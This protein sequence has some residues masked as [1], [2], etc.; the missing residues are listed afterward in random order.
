M[1]ISKK[2]LNSNLRQPLGRTAG[3]A[4]FDHKNR[5]KGVAR[6]ASEI[7]PFPSLSKEA[8]LPPLKNMLHGSSVGI[9]SFA[10][11][12]RPSLQV[13]L[14]VGK[15][16]GVKSDAN[17]GVGHQGLQ[18][19]AESSVGA[20]VK[21]LKSIHGWAD[22]NLIEDI[23]ASVDNDIDTA[24]SLLKSMVSSD[25]ETEE[26]A[27]LSAQKASIMTKCDGKN[28]GAGEK[29]LAEDK[30]VNGVNEL[31]APKQLCKVPIEPEW[32]EDDV[33]LSH[34]KDALRM[35]RVA[36]Q[37]SRAASNA[38]LRGDHFSAHQLSLK[39]REEWMAAER[40]NHKAAEEILRINNNINDMWKLDLHGLHPTEAVT[41]VNERLHKIESQIFLNSSAS[42]DELTA[43]VACTRFP[44]L[45][46]LSSIATDS[47]AAKKKVPSFQRRSVLNIITGIGK[48]SR[49]QAI[50][51][52]AVK[53]FLVEN[54][55]RFEETR[56]GSIAVQ[57]K[58]GH[59]RSMSQ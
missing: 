24:C 41:A 56:P 51:P 50:L 22:D 49:G 14:N 28:K 36:S 43:T 25:P 38:F 21:W 26:A 29:I 16:I 34:R 55:Y 13:S 18:L 52:A 15:Y 45:E 35:M 54:K 12:A 5:E 44:S 27:T 33:Y 46:S 39:A 30:L 6:T 53:N 59:I 23:L 9:K 32:E 10:S 4:A 17:S 42:S 48:N 57:P 31:L 58:F 7:E 11:V 2:P 19:N 8:S 20:S 47:E 37:H 1:T 40:L 3:W